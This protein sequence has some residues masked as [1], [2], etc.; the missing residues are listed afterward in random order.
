MKEEALH[1]Q[2]P[3]DADGEE[4]ADTSALNEHVSALEHHLRGLT[5]TRR[6][7]YSC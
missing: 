2:D 7:I 4:I 1:D 6:G 5:H 3:E